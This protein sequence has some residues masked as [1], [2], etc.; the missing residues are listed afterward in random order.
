MAANKPPLGAEPAGDAVTLA[1]NVSTRYLAFGVEAVLGLLILP[2]NVAHLGASA[3][4]LWMLTASVTAYFS[5]LEF[6]LS[7]SLLKFVAHHRAKKEVNALNETLS[8]MLCVFAGA[9]VMAFAVSGLIALAVDRVFHLAPEQ[10]A[11]ART[12]LLISGFHVAVGMTFGV[13]GAVINGFQRYDL[14]NVVGTVS[15]IAAAA[16]NVTV[17]LLGYGLIGVVAAT[18]AVRLI[19]FLIY[20][21]NAYRVFP[22]LVLRPSAF[23]PERLRELTSF[24]MYMLAID[25]A[26]RVNFMMDALVIGAFLGTSAV[27]VWTVGQRLADVTLR[28]SNQLNDVLFPTI[29]DNDAAARNARLRR[30]FIE[31]TRLSLAAAIPLAGVL[32]LM[33][34]PLIHAW[35]GPGFDGSVAIAQLLAAVVIIRVGTATSTTLLKG[36]GHHRLVALSSSLCAAANLILSIALVK[37]FGIVGVAV[38]TVVPVSLVALFVIFPA[39]CRRVGLTIREAVVRAIWPAAWP[40]LLMVLFVGST[41]DWLSGSLTAIAIESMLAGVVYIAT[42]AFFGLDDHDRRLYLAKLTQLPI[43]RR[44]LP[45]SEGA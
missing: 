4:G 40:A 45:L 14:N 13:F 42:F 5:V 15:S 25:W 19:T 37:P 17:L 30:I 32:I 12:V 28:L 2:L 38:G 39:G 9:G 16:V 35:V 22:G 29:V 33:A 44:L 21:A 10:V 41:R 26:N 34:A 31:A 3:Y 8:T 18:T 24:G 11:T 23:R 36:A 27:A 43:W 1:R 6:G 7:G 20:R